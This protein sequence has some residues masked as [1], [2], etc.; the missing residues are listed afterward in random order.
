METPAWPRVLRPE[1]AVARTLLLGWVFAQVAGASGEWHWPL[2]ARG[3]PHAGGRRQSRLAA[4]SS[5]FPGAPML[6]PAPMGLGCVHPAG[7]E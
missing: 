5:W 7:L 3:A 4:G 2:E 1:T 6:P